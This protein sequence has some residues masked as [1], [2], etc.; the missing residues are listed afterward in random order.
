MKNKEMNKLLSELSHIKEGLK[1]IEFKLI[2]EDIL[3]NG[4]E[5]K[6]ENNI[7]PFEADTI[8][9][10]RKAIKKFTSKMDY[11]QEEK[12]KIEPDKINLN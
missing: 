5:S 12:S 8:R 9:K 10:F 11:I 7:T 2:D 3:L 4:M 6:N 1:R